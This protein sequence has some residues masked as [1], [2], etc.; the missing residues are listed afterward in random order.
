MSPFRLKARQR[1][2]IKTKGRKGIRPRR[3][4]YCAEKW[5]EPGCSWCNA[6]PF[7]SSSSFS[8]SFYLSLATPSVYLSVSIRRRDSPLSRCQC[9]LCWREGGFV[10]QVDEDAR[11][12]PKRSGLSRASVPTACSLACRKFRARARCYGVRVPRVWHEVCQIACVREW[13]RPA[14]PLLVARAY[15]RGSSPPSERNSCTYSVDATTLTLA[16]SRHFGESNDAAR[17][18]RSSYRARHLIP[19]EGE[20]RRRARASE[21]ASVAPLLSSPLCVDTC[22]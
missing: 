21:R 4:A 1:T 11:G 20:T 12:E 14:D 17:W 7:S 18:P 19:R 5:N 15:Q 2:R 16:D 8:S 6:V 22:G 3:S 10:A 9:S 13:S